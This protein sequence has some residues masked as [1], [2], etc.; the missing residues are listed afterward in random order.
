MSNK[1]TNV[2]FGFNKLVFSIFAGS[3]FGDVTIF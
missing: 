1:V 3:C 2:T